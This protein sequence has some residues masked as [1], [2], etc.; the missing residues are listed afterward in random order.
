MMPIKVVY[1]NSYQGSGIGD[2]GK[3]IYDELHANKSVQIRYLESG[4]NWTDLFRIWRSILFTKETAILNM[5][6]TSFGKSPFKNFMN[7][8]LIFIKQRILHKNI[9]IILHDSPDIVNENIS[10]YRFFS[11]MKW[12]GNIATKLMSSSHIIVFSEELKSILIKKYGIKKV[13]YYP[14]PCI[15]EFKS[16]FNSERDDIKIVNV[17]YIAP[18]KGLDI[19][20][21]IK[22][23]LEKSG[24]KNIEFNVIGKPHKLLYKTKK[25]R[26]E[27][28]TLILKLK[29]S[30][31]NVMG[32]VPTR[33]VET[34]LKKGKN[35][36]I[37]PY[38]LEY[39]SSSSA[40]FFIERGI[41]VIAINHKEFIK[42]KE[43]GAGVVT[44][45]TFQDIPKILKSFTEGKNNLM[46]LSKQNREYCE[47]YNVN[48]FIN[49]L[50]KISI[51]S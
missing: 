25:G 26:E 30:G 45:N 47:K 27:I 34:M 24:M 31:V 23:E 51:N 49:V 7:F 14:M 2:F 17:G 43:L 5:G 19:L 41:P 29:K 28:D 33:E 40:I 3:H 16:L 39:G 8:L 21:D 9:L 1:V 32:Y 18:Y 11:L 42:F 36:A 22:K 35:I 4:E 48:N 20:P 37:L 50:L 46:E 44:F 6:F 10:G 38:K 12:G 13:N 15:S